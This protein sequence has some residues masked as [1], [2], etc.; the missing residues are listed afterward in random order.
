MKREG[1]FLSHGETEEL[2]DSWEVEKHGSE[3]GWMERRKDELNTVP[4]GSGWKRELICL[5]GPAFLSAR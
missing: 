1:E 4:V 2:R 5:H 3:D